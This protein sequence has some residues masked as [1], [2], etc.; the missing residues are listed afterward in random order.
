MAPSR[1]LLF[2]GIVLATAGLMGWGLAAVFPPKTSDLGSRAVVT[3]EVQTLLARQDSG[4]LSPEEGFQLVEQLIAI[5]RLDQALEVLALWREDT[6]ASIELN[7]LIADL[8]RRSGDHLGATTDLDQL[9][10]LHPDLLDAIKLKALVQQESGIG[11]EAIR[12][13]QDKLKQA[14]DSNKLSLGLLLADLQRVNGDRNNARGTYQ[15]LAKTFPN[16]ADPV[17]ALALLERE[18]GNSTTV[19]TLLSEARSR[20]SDD[21]SDP[22]IDQLAGR[23]GL[24]AARVRAVQPAAADKP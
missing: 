14:K 1:R 2:S 22:L 4:K 17:I 11:D 12:N 20:R 21:R 18:D 3:R 8:R 10:R 13:I 19:Q 6:P 23:W 15:R 9:L 7:L 5:N 24:S 16:D